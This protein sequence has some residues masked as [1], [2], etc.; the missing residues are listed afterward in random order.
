MPPEFGADD[1]EGPVVVLA[2]SARGDVGVLGGEVGAVVAALPGPGVALLERHLVVVAVAHPDLE[3]ALDVHLHDL[4]LGQPVLGPEQFLED[5]VVERLRAQ[6]SDVELDRLPG[7]ADLAVP[8]HRP[9]RGLATHA[10]EG[11][12]L[13]PL[14]AGL[15]GGERVGRVRVAAAGAGQNRVAV[16]GEPGDGLPAAAG[17]VALEVRHEGT[18]DDAVLEAP[19]EDGG[20]Q[21]TVLAEFV[22]GFVAGPGEEDVAVDARHLV[23]APLP[24]EQVPVG[25][26]LPVPEPG[27]GPGAGGAAL[28]AVH[29][30][31]EAELVLEVEGLVGAGQVL[32]ADD[33]VRARDDAAGAAGTEARVDDLLVE[34]LPLVRPG[35]LGPGGG[36][37]GHHDDP[38][39]RPRNPAVRCVP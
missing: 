10:D 11:E 33:V 2:D 7:L 36:C 26:G 9:D 37:V 13:Q 15:A 39:A 23:G 27:A 30:V 12:G 35:L 16:G 17:A 31:V 21:A 19:D 3:D 18:V 25:L 34:L 32:V 28:L 8:H 1:R 22:D 24:G 6:Q 14:L 29:A 38:S 5:R 20:H 4:V